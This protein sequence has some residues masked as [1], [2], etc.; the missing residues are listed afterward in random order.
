MS[1]LQQTEPLIFTYS[2]KG[3]RA[4]SLPELDVPRQ[5]LSKMLPGVPLREQPASL[6]A[7]SEIEIV[8]HFTRLSQ[9]N[10]AVD[11]GFYPLGSCTMKYNPKLN[12]AAAQLSGFEKLHPYV[13]EEAAQGALQLMAELE[14]W[15]AE[16]GGMARVT[17]QP[18]AGAH[19]EFTGMLIVKA[20]MKSRGQ[21]QRRKVLVPDSAHG[22]NPSS[23]AVAGFHVVEVPSGPDGLLDVEELER[24]LD[25]EVAALML[26]NPNTLGLFER[27]IERIAESTH[28][29]GALL[30]YDGANANAIL[31]H[32]RPGDMGFDIVHFNLHKTFSTPHGG[33]GPGAG[34]V[35]VKAELVP[36]LPVPT[37]EVNQ[38]GV[39]RLDYDRPASV[40][41]VRAFYGNFA[42]LVRA[43]TYIRRLGARGLAEVASI[44]VLNANYVRHKLAAWYDTV[45]ESGCMHEFVLSAHDLHRNHGVRAL[46]IAKALIDR[47]FHPPT[48]YFP[49]I[50][51]EALMIEPTETAS[52]AELDAFIDAM[53]EISETAQSESGAEELRR[54]PQR[55]PFARFDEVSAARKPIIRWQPGP[56]VQKDERHAP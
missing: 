49:L 27:D 51:N 54:A 8:R 5:G 46:D 56:A 23:A 42:T 39:Y 21:L 53:R 40:G 47:G 17:L 15:L 28:R 37:V 36:F 35:G 22:T 30:Y 1:I 19:G 7:V 10:Y 25:D 52:L 6:P 2:A 18:A 29:A 4:S 9:L 31:G 50:V 48:I 13:L 33:G 24:R 32:V 16:I 43:Y 12:D 41:R 11:T 38:H 20:Y 44:A 34:P 14:T 55:A 45:T 3:K 26:T